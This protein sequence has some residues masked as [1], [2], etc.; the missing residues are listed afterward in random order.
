M[1]GS[2]M[3][4]QSPGVEIDFAILAQAA[5]NVPPG[6]FEMFNAGFHSWTW[7]EFP[8]TPP[9]VLVLHLTI[10]PGSFD[11]T[12]MLEVA[13][14]DESDGTVSALSNGPFSSPPHIEDSARPTYAGAV[15]PLDSLIIP[16]PGAY[17]FRIIVDGRLIGTIPFWAR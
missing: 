17:T 14:V 6:K 10:S 8:A 13:F 2:G 7:E 5:R 12:H 1:K 9:F 15:I 4:E 11:S 3:K 16:A